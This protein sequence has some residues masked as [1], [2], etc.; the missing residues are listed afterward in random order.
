MAERRPPTFRPG[1]IIAALE[2]HKVEYILIGGFAAVAH[3]APHIT[4]DIDITPKGDP[5]NLTRL[6]EA[7]SD[8]GARVRGDREGRD[9]F[10]FRHDATSLSRQAVLN[11][12]TRVGNLDVSVVP[13]GTQ[14][15]DDLRR[16]AVE[17]SVDGTPVRV[18]SLADVIRSKEAAN[19]PKDRTSLPVL[20]RLLEE[21]RHRERGDQP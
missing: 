16:D 4:N 10:D 18:A 12:T 5:D 15:Y 14:G 1:E 13:S 8:L 9:T 2:R 6:S 7:L 11:L 19:R 20:R 21:Q 17:I 3:G